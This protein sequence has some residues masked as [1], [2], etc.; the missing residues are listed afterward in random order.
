MTTIPASQLVNVIPNVLNAGG[1]ALVMNGL[2]LTHNTRV[3]T[4][5]VLSFPNDGISVSNFFGASSEEAEIA[6][7][8]FNGFNNSTQKPATILFAQ[9]PSAS[10]A[11]YLRGGRAAQLSLAQLK[12]LTGTLLVDVDGFVR[13]ANALDLSGAT[14]FSAAAALIETGLNAVPPQAA[15][16]TGAI[17]AATAAV[18]ASIAGYVMYVTG[19]TSGTLVAGAVVSGAGVAAG[20]AIT[21]Q[22]SGTTGG[23]GEYAVS[24][25]QVVPSEAISASYGTLTVTAIASGTLSVGQT[26]AGTGVTAGT[27]ITQLGTGS[28]LAGTY[29]VNLTQTAASGTVTA[30]ATPLEVSFDSVAGAFV[31]TS[32]V[33]GEASTVDF[34]TGTLADDL[35]L[36]QAT[37]AVLSQGADGTTPAAFMTNITQVTQNWATFMSIFDPDDGSGSVQKQAFSAWVN[38]TN[39]RY[40]YI[41]WDTDIVPTESEDATSSFGSIIKAANL[42]GTCAIYQPDGGPT[43]PAEIAAF[44]CGAAASIDFQQTNGRITFA[45]RGQDGLV[46]GVST[47]TVANNLF[48]NGYNFYGAYATAAQQFLEFQN[49]TVSGE[50]EWLDSYINQIWLNSQL[51]LALMELL[52]N[53]NSVPYNTAGFELIKAACLDPINQALNFGA[54]RAG[55]TLSALQIAEINSAAGVKASDTLQ[56][57]GWYLQVKDATPQVRQARQSPP[58]NFFYMDGESVQQIELTSTLVQ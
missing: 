7:V 32:G 14:S 18:T 15:T 25:E 26:L 24:I 55:V 37:G 38:S 53:V 31:I 9:Y 11:A 16:V 43:T 49:G 50:F 45:F 10:V 3:P 5:Q 30:S 34:A 33:A 57:Q 46:A 19:V 17:A 21:N 27:R 54:I 20:T 1:N 52:Q 35:F 36:T 23:I 48:A 12:A 13:T 41:A 58:I 29:F 40:A 4:G 56:L 2:V 39:K 44:I 28:G 42:D 6:A 22:L 51:Q 47:A 8:Y